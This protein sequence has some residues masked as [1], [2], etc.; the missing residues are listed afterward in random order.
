MS[1]AIA[2]AIVALCLALV[3]RG[4]WRWYKG[5]GACGCSH[6]PLSEQAEQ[7]RKR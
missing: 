3:G 6:C 5:R 4:V 7:R 1:D 2:I